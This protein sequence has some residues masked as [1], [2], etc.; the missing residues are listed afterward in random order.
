MSAAKQ[1][2]RTVIALFESE[3]DNRAAEEGFNVRYIDQS[4]H[5]VLFLVLLL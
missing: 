3:L 1:H 5:Q 2:A 4:I